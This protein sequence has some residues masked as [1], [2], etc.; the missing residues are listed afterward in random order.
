[1]ITKDIYFVSW[2]QLQ[3]LMTK[4]KYRIEITQKHKNKFCTHET[5]QVTYLSNHESKILYGIKDS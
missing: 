4:Q 5:I 1:M 2:L 3:W